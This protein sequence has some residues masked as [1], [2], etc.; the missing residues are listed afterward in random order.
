[1]TQYYFQLLNEPGTHIDFPRNGN[2]ATIP[3]LTFDTHN[4]ACRTSGYNA[5]PSQVGDADHVLI[6]TT[7]N[8]CPSSFTP[9]RQHHKTN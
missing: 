8:I 6:S 9:Q 3:D 1:M 7:L 2:R 4:G 5:D